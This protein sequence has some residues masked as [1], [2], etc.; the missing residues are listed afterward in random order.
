[1][2]HT[3]RRP[4]GR[5]HYALRCVAES[6]EDCWRRTRWIVQ[7]REPIL[8]RACVDDWPLKA[9]NA[10]ACN[11][12]AAAAV[13]RRACVCVWWSL[14]NKAIMAV[15]DLAFYTTAA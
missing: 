6:S 15:S 8:R 9:V 12:C 7:P 1:M 5:A 2:R 3:D 13:I 14:Y 4:R 10:T 11:C